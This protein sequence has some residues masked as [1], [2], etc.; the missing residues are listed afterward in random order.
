VRERLLIPLGK[1]FRGEEQALAEY[2]QA[3]ASVLADYAADRPEVL[4]DLLLA[5]DP[6]QYAVLFPVLQAHREQAVLRMREALLRKPRAEPDESLARSQA[7]AAVTLLR[8]DEPADAWPLFRHTADP[9]ARAHLVQ[10]CN[11]LGVEAEALVRRLDE[12]KE[13]SARRALIL[14]LGDYQEKDLPAEVR[15]PLLQKLLGWYRDDPD[16]GIHGAIDWLLRHGTEGPEDR[17]LDWG[18]AKA[19]E[20]IDDSLRRQG[21]DE[22][23]RWYVNGHGQTLVLIPGP[24]EFPMGS[25]PSDPERGKDERRHLCRIPRSFAIASKPVTVADFERFLKARPDVGHNVSKRSS[26]EPAVPISG[27]TWFEAAQYCNWL[28]EQEGI[29]KD[30]W[31]Y[32]EPIK[33]GM[34]PFP[35]YL[36]REAY[37][38][39][40]E[41]EWEYACRAGTET[42]RYCDRTATLTS[43]SVSP[44]LST[45]L[46]R[47]RPRGDTQMESPEAVGLRPVQFLAEVEGCGGPRPAGIFPLRLRRQLESVARL[48]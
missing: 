44:G 42:S 22:K 32:P 5:A 2:R 26:P 28:S 15:G 3:A 29:P 27:V 40:S 18:Q 33:E 23:R 19:L 9:T 45:K 39:P 1:V 11:L 35:D 14:A 13:V 30:Q 20:K 21:P 16:P 46:L 31:C 48:A 25:P 17:P 43:A 38:L 10:R 7:T 8:L 24:V 12:E 36:K 37:R 4:A 41:A 6:K 47:G 34:T